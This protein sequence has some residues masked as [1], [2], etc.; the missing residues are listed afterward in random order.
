MAANTANAWTWSAE[1]QDYY[2]Y[3]VRKYSFS[4]SRPKECSTYPITATSPK[5]IGLQIYKNMSGNPARSLAN[6]RALSVLKTGE[7]NDP[8]ISIKFVRCVP[9]I[10]DTP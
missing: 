4:V 9:I 7:I 2:Y 10:A 5:L 3:N 8:H 6:I 1:Q